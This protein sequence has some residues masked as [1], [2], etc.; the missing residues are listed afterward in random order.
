MSLTTWVQIPQDAETFLLSPAI[1]RCREG[2]SAPFKDKLV[3][4]L[5]ATASHLA[6][7][8]GARAAAAA[9]L[10]RRRQSSSV[11]RACATAASASCLCTRV[12]GCAFARLTSC[13]Y[14]CAFTSGQACACAGMRRRGTH[15]SAADT[16]RTALAHASAVAPPGPA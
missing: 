13:A 7:A 10:R 8:A 3:Y 14:A 16:A 4:L 5:V 1:L 9:H 12:H 2:Q 15:L 6:N 11:P